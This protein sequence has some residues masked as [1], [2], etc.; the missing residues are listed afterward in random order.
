MI[1]VGQIFIVT[2]GGPFFSVTP[3]RIT[4]WLWIIGGTSLVLW[5]GELV[6]MFRNRAAV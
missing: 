6:R 2:V 5:L 4:D 3:L 1:L